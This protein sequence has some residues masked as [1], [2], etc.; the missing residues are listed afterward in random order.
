MNWI[1]PFFIVWTILGLAI[2]KKSYAEVNFRDMWIGIYFGER[3]TYVCFIPFLVF[4]FP[5]KEKA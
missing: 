1:Y 3:T 5:K 4:V 2:I